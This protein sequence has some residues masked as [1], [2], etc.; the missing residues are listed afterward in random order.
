MNGVFKP[1]QSAEEGFLKSSLA[2]SLSCT[3]Q[4]IEENRIIDLSRTPASNEAV[5]IESSP[6][7]SSSMPCSVFADLS[8]KIRTRIEG[9]NPE[10]SGRNEAFQF[11]R[12]K[13]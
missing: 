13:R 6:A 7:T 5:P 4:A 9:S 2:D 12:R 11:F 1:S 8:Q 3:A 10:A